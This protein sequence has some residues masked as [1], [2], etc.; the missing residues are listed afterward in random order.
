MIFHWFVISQALS[1]LGM[2]FFMMA[3]WRLRFNKRSVGVVIS[4]SFGSAIINYL[5]IAPKVGLAFIV[6]LLSFTI[7]FCFL[8][9]VFKKPRKIPVFWSFLLSMYANAA[10]FLIQIILLYCSF[11]F[12]SAGALKQHLWRNYLLDSVTGLLLFGVTWLLN[13]Y[14]IGFTREFDKLQFKW[15]KYIIP[16]VIGLS[17]LSFS[18]IILVMDYSDDAS[19]SLPL[20][21]ASVILAAL[22]LVILWFAIHKE[23]EEFA[24]YKSKRKGGNLHWP[25]N[26]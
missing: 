24:N 10:P 1:A 6:P 22:F 26:L 19:F 4:I 17:A 25:K 21:I 3:S 16:P 9:G 13:K 18:S 7:I 8:L 15:E 12:F 11:G 20:V 23:K 5:V 14:G 2:I